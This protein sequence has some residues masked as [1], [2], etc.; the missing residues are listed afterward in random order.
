MW[1]RISR[2]VEHSS[3]QRE[4]DVPSPITLFALHLSNQPRSLEPLLYIRVKSSSPYPPAPFQQLSREVKATKWQLV[5]G[6]S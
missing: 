3:D 5:L 2:R 1:S 4:S 6:F